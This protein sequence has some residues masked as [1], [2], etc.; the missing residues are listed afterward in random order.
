MLIILSLAFATGAACG[1]AQLK[2]WALFPIIVGFL[3]V[4]FVIGSSMDLTL[5]KITLVL[6]VACMMIQ[7]VYL[8]GTA[9]FGMTPRQQL[10]DD[11]RPKQ[12]PLSAIQKAIAD[13]LQVYFVPP[14]DLPQLGSEL[15]NFSV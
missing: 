2:V 8:I 12:G 7:V 11:S 1:L 9:I 15:I 5:G 6:L 14:D 10:S 13:E 4:A 3:L